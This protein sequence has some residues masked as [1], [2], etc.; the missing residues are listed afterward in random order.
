MKRA[1]NQKL[2]IVSLDDPGLEIPKDD[3]RLNK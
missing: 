1:F 3:G 2:L